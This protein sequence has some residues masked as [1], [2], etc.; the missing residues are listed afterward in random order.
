MKFAWEMVGT[1]SEQKLRP[2]SIHKIGLKDIDFSF[3]Q[4]SFHPSTGRERNVRG[5]RKPMQ[6]LQQKK[7]LTRKLENS[8]SACFVG[9]LLPFTLL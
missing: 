6:Q 9:F 2:T 5:D 1:K 3:H 7:Y 4:G 8:S